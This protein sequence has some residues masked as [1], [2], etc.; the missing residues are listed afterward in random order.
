MVTTGGQSREGPPGQRSVLVTPSGAAV[1]SAQRPTRRRSR[2][3]SDGPS[4]QQREAARREAERKE[5]ELRDRSSTI[6]NQTF[7]SKAAKEAAEKD[8]LAKQEA[9]RQQQIQEQKLKPR[10]EIG[11]GNII[12]REQELTTKIS[13][14]AAL[15]ASAKNLG[16]VDRLRNQGFK[17]FASNIFEPFSRTNL[18]G[19]QDTPGEIFVTGRGTQ[20]TEV[21]STPL[22]FRAN[23]QLSTA[24][25][26]IKERIK[27][28]ESIET[29][30]VP[31]EVGL[32]NINKRISKKLPP[33]PVPQNSS[34]DPNFNINE[35]AL[36]LEGP[37]GDQFR[38]AQKDLDRESKEFLGKRSSATTNVQNIVAQED[39]K[40]EADFIGSTAALTATGGLGIAGRAAVG[41][42]IAGGSSLNFGKALTG[43][44]LTTGER[45]K[46]AGA[47]TVQAG[48]GFAGI[49]SALAPKPT[50]LIATSERRDTLGEL[51][52]RPLRVTGNEFI[53]QGDD[54][55]L[56]LRFERSTGGGSASQ[57]IDALVPTSTIGRGN[58][59]RSPKG[60]LSDFGPGGVGAF[61][62]ETTLQK[63]VTQGGRVSTK[64]NVFVESAGP[65]G[66]L[67]KSSQNFGLSGFVRPNQLGKG[68]TSFLGEGMLTRRGS[69]EINTFPVAGISQTNRRGTQAAVVGI[70]PT[71]LKSG[72]NIPALRTNQVSNPF[73]SSSGRGSGLIDRLPN[74]KIPSLS[75]NIDIPKSS[76]FTQFR[77]S[78][79]S[80]PFSKTFTQTGQS[81]NLPSFPANYPRA[82]RS[83]PGPSRQFT[84]GLD[85]IKPRTVVGGKV[86]AFGTI[87]LAQ[88]SGP[89]FTTFRGGASGKKPSSGVIQT[90]TQNLEI[91]GGSVIGA[92]ASGRAGSASI[93]NLQPSRAAGRPFSTTS[94][95]QQSNRLSTPTRRS[96]LDLN[97]QRQTGRDVTLL[98]NTQ[99][100]R[101]NERIRFGRSTNLA[102]PQTINTQKPRTNVIPLI[103]SGQTPSSRSRGR[104]RSASPLAPGAFTG[105][106]ASLNL[107]R[108]TPPP[109]PILSLGGSLSTARGKRR[110]A[111][112]S[113]TRN[114]PSFRA[115]AFNIRG[116]AR[117]R[118]PSGLQFSP[119]PKGFSFENVFK[120]KPKR[121]RKKRR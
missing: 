1:G 102:P 63:I 64:T 3:R 112:Q 106:G 101:T 94:S 46:L 48:I 57:Q 83:S 42:F 35:F 118:G 44:D 38:K 61:V 22:E 72:N 55:I 88:G 87:N 37:V 80:T 20:I 28:G 78:G 76:S 121:R 26:T 120:Q 45:L 117:S 15:V 54:S 23:S 2:G 97:P 49:S 71:T 77:G 53:K 79:A 116:R 34:L 103:R 85:N 25:L 107:F 92:S 65:T 95:S 17:S 8:F 16:D 58:L 100:P 75:R 66:R 114:I 105:G 52:R 109:P 10:L 67:F 110:F 31:E 29:I 73:V 40:D 115:L 32:E 91:Q 43:D 21:S 82:I 108:G 56:R 39:L 50:S 13:G 96:T 5:Q 93:L 119:I 68:Q 81:A 70:N 47:G 51:E 36:N 90:S 14:G 27:A 24:E 98:S 99:K 113:V 62:P 84:S 19:R 18:V 6:L 86:N 111:G 59:L 89:T 11:Q 74:Q 9:T 104:L 60:T 41:G 69:S 4:P 33:V 12:S 7:E 30:G